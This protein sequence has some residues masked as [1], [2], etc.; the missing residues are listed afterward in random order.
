MATIN[1]PTINPT[2]KLSASVIAI[3]IIEIARVI[4]HNFFPAFDDAGLWTALSPVVVFAIGYFVKDEANVV[5]AVPVAQKET[6]TSEVQVVD[7]T[8]IKA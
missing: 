7:Y 4:T 1:Q 3:A 2:N 6:P 5:L 8:D